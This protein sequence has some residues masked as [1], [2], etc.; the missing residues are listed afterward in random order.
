M[1]ICSMLVL[2]LSV[3]IAS[4][5]PRS[6]PPM[7]DDIEA[8]KAHFAAGSA[9]Y[10]Q[11]NYQDALKE[12]NEALRLS[13]RNDLLYNIAMCYERLNQLDNAIAAL[14]RYLREKPNAPDRVLIHTRIAAL[15]QRKK[16]PQEVA[17][18]PLP[19]PT[20]VVEPVPVPVPVPTPGVVTPPAP[21]R[22]PGWYVPGVA[23]GAVAVA[24]LVTAL[25]TGI[26]SNNIHNELVLQCPSD[27]CPDSLRGE[28]SKGRNL[29]LVTDVMVAVGAAAAITSVV[30][31]VVKSRTPSKQA[32]AGRTPVVATADGILLYF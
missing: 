6:A 11:A 18:K 15:Q 32:R 5:Q 7:A 20:P 1:K 21:T 17:P 10:E 19:T 12:F 9:Y 29:A 23:V 24:A 22:A 2:M 14:Q 13:K 16:E 25:G 4:A 8:A 3:S 31:L 27:L 26:S 30:L 28:V